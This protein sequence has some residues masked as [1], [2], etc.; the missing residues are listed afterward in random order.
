MPEP[1]A[2]KHDDYIAR[3]LRTGEARVI[4]RS[5][6]L[7]ALRRDGIPFPIELNLTEFRFGGARRSTASI[8]DISERR[9]A[10]DHIQ[11]LW[12]SDGLTDVL[13]KAAD[14]AMYNA[15][16]VGNSFR[17]FGA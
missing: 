17:F 5:R 3:Y 4:G 6:E 13:V 7:S 9:Q 1:H 2:G 16:Q 8:R 11:R 15:K 14:G 10:E 12:H